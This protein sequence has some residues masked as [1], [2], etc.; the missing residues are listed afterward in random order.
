MHTCKILKNDSCIGVLLNINP[1]EKLLGLRKKICTEILHS[2]KDF[3]FLFNKVSVS[4]FQE[5]MFDLKTIG[6]VSNQLGHEVF[7]LEVAE[8]E[9]KIDMVIEEAD[10]VEITKV[11]DTTPSSKKCALKR[12]SFLRSPEAWE[13]KKMKIYTDTEVE[14]SVGKVKEYREFWNSHA[15]SLSKTMRTENRSEISKVIHQKWQGNNIGSIEDSN[16]TLIRN[17]E[18]IRNALNE[19]EKAESDVKMEKY[20]KKR[21]LAYLSVELKR[22]RDSL[23]KNKA[24]VPL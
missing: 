11:V 1:L 17:K 2:G 21:R 20:E 10:M 15:K 14:G 13:M 3:S 12:K 19:I 5:N 18:R 7:V 4:N 16:K 24:K 9:P 23:R 6:K 22:A 8:M